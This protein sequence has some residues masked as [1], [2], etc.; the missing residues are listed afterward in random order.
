MKVVCIND[1]LDGEKRS[2]MTKGKVYDVIEDLSYMHIYKMIYDKGFVNIFLKERFELI[3]N[4]R[5]ERI[6]KIL[7][8]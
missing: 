1:T 7:E 2:D 6:S 4:R 3:Y 8:K 5:M